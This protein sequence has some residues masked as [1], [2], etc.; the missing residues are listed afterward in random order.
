MNVYRNHIKYNTL[1]ND[2]SWESWYASMGL[3]I[4]NRSGLY[5]IDN[6]SNIS[7]KEMIDSDKTYIEIVFKTP[8]T[9]RFYNNHSWKMDNIF[10]FLYCIENGNLWY[11]TK[12]DSI[13][14]FAQYDNS[15]YQYDVDED[16]VNDIHEWLK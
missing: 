4:N 10:Y 5:D 12:K 11:G 14:Y 2:T 3:D 1:N 13:I 16:L 15:E 8:Q 9:F 7:S 6:V